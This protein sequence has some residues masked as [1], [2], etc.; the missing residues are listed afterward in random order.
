MVDNQASDAAIIICRVASRISA[1]IRYGVL[2]LGLGEFLNSLP[3]FLE[4]FKTL[5]TSQTSLW[6]I[7]P[8][9]GR[10][11]PVRVGQ[12][13]ESTYHRIALMAACDMAKSLRLMTVRLN[14]DPDGGGTDLGAILLG[15]DSLYEIGLSGQPFTDDQRKASCAFASKRDSLFLS[16]EVWNEIAVGLAFER[17]SLQGPSH[18]IDKPDDTIA[19]ADSDDGETARVSDRGRDSRPIIE[20]PSGLSKTQQ[21]LVD[22]MWPSVES[23]T[24]KRPI[25]EV[26]MEVWGDEEKESTALRSA[27]TRLN[28][29]CSEQGSSFAI[30]KEGDFLVVKI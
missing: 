9:P 17:K 28:D 26:V 2:D 3:I 6:S 15:I 16:P 18:E 10:F 8:P 22:S 25:S 11:E 27:I 23:Q 29:K 19:N 20:K 30:H 13:A 24:F 14:G 1:A 4:Q 21:R 12:F 5:E 7:K